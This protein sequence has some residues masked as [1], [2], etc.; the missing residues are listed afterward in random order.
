MDKLFYLVID[1]EIPKFKQISLSS[2]LVPTKQLIKIPIPLNLKLI[3]I[4]N[5][6]SLSP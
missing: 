4:K 3:S 1:A 6:Y 2:L 5:E